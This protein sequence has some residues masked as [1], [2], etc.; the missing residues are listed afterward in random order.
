V[1]PVG[2]VRQ[3]GVAEASEQ[4]LDSMAMDGEKTA[5]VKRGNVQ[6]PTYMVIEIARAARSKR[7]VATL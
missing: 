7:P 6:E 2:A 3:V 4:V 1:A 5:D